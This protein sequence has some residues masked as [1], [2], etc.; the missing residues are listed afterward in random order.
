MSK[1][2]K[3]LLGVAVVGAAVAGGY[4]LLQVLREKK[5]V[6]DETVTSVQ[7]QLDE[8]DPVSRAAVVAKLTSDEAK[9]LRPPKH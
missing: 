3:A 9:T 8:L 4:F 5:A 6:V 7:T 2:A 1:G